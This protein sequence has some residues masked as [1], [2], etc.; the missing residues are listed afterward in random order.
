MTAEHAL[1]LERWLLSRTRDQESAR[2]EWART[3][4][5]VL[6]C[7]TLFSAVRMPAD[8][9]EAAAGSEDPEAINAYLGRALHVGAVFVDTTCRWFYFLVPAGTRHRWNIP[10]TVCL[11]SNT[12]VGVP[13]PGSLHGT[14]TPRSYWCVEMDGPDSLCVPNAVVQLAVHARYQVVEA[15]GTVNIGDV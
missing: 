15:G 14:G 1:T 2:A 12:Y 8:W 4:V 9:I 5:A 13:R 6:R 7:G 10:G 3:G 11:G